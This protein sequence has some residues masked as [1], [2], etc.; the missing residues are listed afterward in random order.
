MPSILVVEQEPHSVERINAALGAEG[1]RVR[2]VPSV[3]QA[4]HAASAEPPD[5]VMAGTDVP[6]F[7]V[8]TFSFSRRSGGPGVVALDPGNGGGPAGA[9]DARLA[10]PFTDQQVVLAARQ[11]LLARRQPTPAP[12]GPEQKLT[13]KDIFGDVLAEVEGDMPPRPVIAPP[14]AT[15][16]P[17]PPTADVQRRLEETLSGLLGGEP[18]PKPAP[19]APAAAP[20]RRAEL[21][22]GDVDAL[23]SK[24]LSNLDLGKTK[25]GVRATGPQPIVRPPAPPAPAP[26]AP[27]PPQPQPPVSEGTGVRKGRALGDFDFAEL[28]ELAHP[29]RPAS[30]GTGVRP[31]V[32]TPVPVPPPPVAITPPPPM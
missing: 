14:R 16:P 4:L 9:A 30:Q 10:K 27:A 25:T 2:V 6:G 31:I 7:E 21:A 19:A 23:L 8:L 26:P 29:T 32:P 3:D 11:A 28:E 22:A 12:M 24:T 20:P 15:P 13:S 17:P 5:L 18:K 1:W